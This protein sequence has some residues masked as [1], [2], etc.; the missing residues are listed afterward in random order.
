MACLRRAQVLVTF[1]GKPVQYLR[2]LGNSLQRPIK[3]HNEG[4]DPCR[5]KL[6]IAGKKIDGR[7]WIFGG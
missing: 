7:D 5:Q 1:R 6:I 3:G 2:T 4:F